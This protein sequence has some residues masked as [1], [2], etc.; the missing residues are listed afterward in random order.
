MIALTYVLSD[1]HGRQDRFRDILK[2][3]KFSDCDELYIL[4]DV[5]DRNPDGIRILKQIMQAN[6]MHMLMGNH[7]H[8]M[9]HA[10]QEPTR[11]MNEWFTYIDLWFYNGGEITLKAYEQLS[12]KEKKSIMDFISILPLNIPLTVAQKSYLLVHGSPVSQYE[13]NNVD[14]DDEASFAVW[15]RLD[16]FAENKFPEMTIICGHTPTVYFNPVS[17][18]EVFC[19]NNV[20]CM[21][22]GCAYSSLAGGRLACMCLEDGAVFYSE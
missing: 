4:G 21:D 5:I 17:P 18:M 22:C 11:R 12:E 13:P 8:M 1:I 10:V 20:I 2:K 7:E 6:N 9:L 3:I 15:N 14:Y 16:P 19:K